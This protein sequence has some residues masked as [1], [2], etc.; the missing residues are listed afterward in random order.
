M[1]REQIAEATGTSNYTGGTLD[2][3]GGNLHPLTYALGLARAAQ[4]AGATLHANSR[5]LSVEQVGDRQVI[6]TATGRLAARRVVLAT[7][8]YT[9]GLAPPLARTLVPVRSIQVATAPLGDD[10]AGSILPGR[11]AASDSQRLLLYYRKTVDGRFIMG[12]RGAY[13]D[14][15]TLR[16]MQNLRAASL[17]LY[18]QLAGVDWTHAWGGFVAVTADHTPHLTRHGEGR[19][20]ALG[21]NGRGVAMATAMG[22]VLADW[23]TGRPEADLDFPVT[24]PAPIAFHALRKPAVSATVAWYRLKDRLGL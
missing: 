21:Y 13:G 5:V 11:Q 14:T 15:A 6:H 1:T 19:I 3:R 10:L 17:S 23:A 7:N 2:P 8:G 20:A 12:G 18:P 9:D 16:L 24:D 4:A 22:R